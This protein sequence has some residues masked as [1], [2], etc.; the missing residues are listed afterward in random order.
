MLSRT[1]AIATRSN[2]SI[3]TRFYSSE[4][5]TGSTRSDGSSD[6]FT[7]QEDYYIKK[8]QAE[9]IAKL[10]EQLAKQKEQLDT[11]EGGDQWGR[12]VCVEVLN[13]GVHVVDSQRSDVSQ[14]LDLVGDLLDLVIRQVEVQ[15]L[16]SALDGIPSRQSVGKVDVSGQAEIRWVQDLVGG[17]VGQDGL[18]MDTGLVGE[19]AETGDWVV[20]RN[21]H[22]NS[23]CNQVLQISQFV[24]LVLGHDVLSVCSNHSGHQTSQR[25]DTVSLSN[26][27][28]RNV[29]QLGTGLQSSVRVGNGASGVVVEMALDVARNNALQRLDKLVHL[30]WVGASNSVGNTN[31]VHTNLVDG[32]INI[33]QVHDV[34]SERVLGRESDLDTFGLD[35]LNHLHRRFGDVRHVL[36]VRVLS[37]E[38]RSSNNNIDTINTSLDSNFCVVHVTSDMGQNL[39]FQSQLANRLAISPTLFRG[40]RRGQLDVV[41]SKI[42]QSLGNLYFLLGGEKGVGKLLTFSQSRFNQLE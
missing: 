8:H 28:Q 33:E 20:E 38:L 29:N 36:T 21:V 23:L 30:S 25:S 40:D 4:G 6:A 2:R 22:L 12:D 41:H 5:S 1:V 17:W 14:L 19:G 3:V 34:G 10:K 31:S 27:K 16:D 18:G 26:T 9:Q 39:G 35:K 37:Q 11:L 24:Q 15:L 42:I 7:A 13:D 32:L